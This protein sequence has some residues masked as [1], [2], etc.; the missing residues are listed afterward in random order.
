MTNGLTAERKLKKVTIMLMRSQLFADWSGILML[1]SKTV[2]DN[3]PTAATNGRDEIYGRA[4]VDGLPEPELAFVVLHE[5]AHKMLRQLTVWEKLWKEDP[6]LANAA[7]DYVANQ[8]I[9]A[10]DPVGSVVKVP[11]CGALLSPRFKDMNTKQVFDILKQEQ[12]SGGGAGGGP[13]DPLDEHDW[14]GANDLTKQEQEQ[15]AREVDQAIRQGQ[16]T[17]RKFGNG[18]G[19][20]AKEL[21]E[22]LAPKVDWREQLRE[23]VSSYCAGK[24][25]SS[26]RRVNR[27]FI[28]HDVYLPSLISETVKHVVIGVDMSGSTW[29]GDT[30]QKFFTEMVA[31]SDAV[32]PERLDLVY[33]DT[34]VCNVET[35]GQGDYDNLASV[36]KP[37]GGGGTN[38]ACVS[39]YLRENK[40][41]PD[42]VIVLTDG[43]V[44]NWGDG[45]VAP[46]MWAIT[47]PGRPV[48][49]DNGVTINLD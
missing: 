9:V 21:G 35:Y 43:E 15:L 24:D 18:S 11:S 37:K 29:V 16:A 34:S 41:T 14:G 47:N 31:L 10:R 20:M 26:W 32:R 12:K 13:G 39:K 28:A 2:V 23:F 46:V 19:D 22:L 36:T 17:A 42:C 5:S 1:G 45:W 48:V 33:W 40:L 3:C 8:M 27:R 4:F 38:P 30:L 7:A 25:A 44:P 49:A 6:R